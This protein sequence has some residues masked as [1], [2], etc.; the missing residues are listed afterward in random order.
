MVDLWNVQ[1]WVLYCVGC[2]VCVNCAEDVNYADEKTAKSRGVLMLCDVPVALSVLECSWWGGVGILC[3]SVSLDYISDAIAIH[4]VSMS[5]M[6]RNG[7][8]G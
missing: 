5:R 3:M 4:E 8:G 1:D 2:A 6:T 7:G